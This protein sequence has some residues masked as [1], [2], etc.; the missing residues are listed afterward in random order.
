M[1]P[2]WQCTFRFA[3]VHIELVKNPGPIRPMQDNPVPPGITGAFQRLLQIYREYR[4]AAVRPDAQS[5]E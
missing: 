1:S 3:C 5:S 4:T 2:L